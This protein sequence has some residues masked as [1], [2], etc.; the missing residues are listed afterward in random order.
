MKGFLICALLL[1]TGR[2]WADLSDSGNLVI[3][4][5]ATI[6]GSAFSVGGA[7]LSVSGGI[8][9][10]GGQLNM[11]AGGVRWADGTVTTSSSASSGAI[12]QVSSG[13]MNSFITTSGESARFPLD[14]NIPQI[15]QGIEVA[16]ATIVATSSSSRIIVWGVTNAANSGSG[17]HMAAALFKNSESNAISVASSGQPDSDRIQN[18]AVM[19]STIAATTSPLVFRLRAGCNAPSG[20]TLSIN[21]V[22]GGRVYGGKMQSALIVQE[23]RP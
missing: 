9:S 11:A 1:S 7:T 16:S 6:Q 10:L 21:G 4:G 22:S 17:Y 15:T 12:I 8:I 19:Y 3:G 23:V 18:L 20:T 14:D 5:T 13:V 2:A